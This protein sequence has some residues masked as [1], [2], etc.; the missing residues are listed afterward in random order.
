MGGLL[1]FDLAGGIDAGQRFVEATAIAR[2]AT[3]LGGPETLVCH[4]ALPVP[5]SA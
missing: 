5:M 4:W 1:T 2:Q 3:S